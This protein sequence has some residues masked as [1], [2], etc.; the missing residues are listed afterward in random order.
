MKIDTSIF[1]YHVSYDEIY[2]SKAFI[3]RAPSIYKPFFLT[4]NLQDIKTIYSQT[5]HTST[6]A[7]I[8]QKVKQ[9][10][11]SYNIQIFA[12]KDDSMNFI[13]ISQKNAG[14]IRK[15]LKSNGIEAFFPIDDEYLT[16]EKIVFSIINLNE[17]SKSILAYCHEIQHALKYLNA[18]KDDESKIVLF[19]D[20]IQ[21][22]IQSINNKDFTNY[23]YDTCNNDVQKKFLNIAFSSNLFSEA[24]ILNTV[25][26]RLY[27]DPDKITYEKS[28]HFFKALTTQIVDCMKSS[29]KLQ[30]VVHGKDSNNIKNVATSLIEMFNLAGY[31]GFYSKKFN[32]HT[33]ATWSEKILDCC[34]Y[35]G[36]KNTDFDV[37][38]GTNKLKLNLR[39]V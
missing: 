2:D 26:K 25:D 8:R 12:F 28:K 4:D 34:V 37:V 23:N 7:E 11:S 27:F 24:H 19:Y 32:G 30:Y 16:F 14:Q 3:L 22:M 9:Q 6:F 39:N 15:I 35:H 13:D 33:L 29:D 36:M 20:C 31:D 17:L 1:Y 5:C 18:L 38:D 21:K 10:S